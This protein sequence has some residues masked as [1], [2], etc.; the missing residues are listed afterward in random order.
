MSIARV[1]ARILLRDLADI[2]VSPTKIVNILTKS[3]FSYR[4]QDMFRDANRALGWAK[5]RSATAAAEGPRIGFRPTAPSWELPDGERYKTFG[6][7]IWHDEISGMDIEKDSCFFSDV[8]WENDQDI[9]DEFNDLFASDERYRG[10]TFAGFRVEGT[11]HN[12][13]MP[14]LRLTK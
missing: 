12:V 4:R 5:I 10:L 3:A 14:H 11:E 8:L 9:E 2:Y 7:S 1:A 6:K 13:D